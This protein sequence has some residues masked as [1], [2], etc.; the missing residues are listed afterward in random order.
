MKD[1]TRQISTNSTHKAK[2]LEVIQALAG[3]ASKAEAARLAGVDRTTIY[4][5]CKDDPDFE[6][7]LMLAQG[8]CADAMKAQVR[9]L[10]EEALK[11]VSEI[12]KGADIPPVVRLKAASIVLHIEAMMRESTSAA[13][14]VEKWRYA[15]DIADAFRSAK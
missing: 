12:M 8:E 7:Q 5:W 10:R 6:A 3:G 11:T 9:E 1:N 14:V 2:Q 4:Y 13:A 15:R